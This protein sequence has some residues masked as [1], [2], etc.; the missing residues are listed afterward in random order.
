[1]T[2]LPVS[3]PQPIR[4]V[5]VA[6]VVI[7]NRPTK[8]FDT[9]FKPESGYRQKMVAK[10]KLTQVVTGNWALDAELAASS[11]FKAAKSRTITYV[12]PLSIPIPMSPKQCD[13]IEQQS[14]GD[15]R[16]LFTFLTS[17]PY[18]LFNPF[19]TPFLS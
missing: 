9:I 13:V 3:C 15:P 7:P 17:S 10:E 6:E 11:G 1:M 12:R 16:Q 18:M 19:L 8:V 2:C 14:V 5:T 4:D